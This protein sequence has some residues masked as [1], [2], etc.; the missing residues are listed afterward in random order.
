MAIASPSLGV[1]M[2]PGVS[3]IMTP[4]PERKRDRLMLETPPLA[5]GTPD[6]AHR[7]MAAARHSQYRNDRD[8]P[9]NSATRNTTPS[10]ERS[11]PIKLRR[12]SVAKPPQ[13][14]LS[15]AST[16]QVYREHQNTNPTAQYLTVRIDKGPSESLGMSV[17]GRPST[18]FARHSHSHHIVPLC[19]CV[20]T[21]ASSSSDCRSPSPFF[22]APAAKIPGSG[23]PRLPM[24]DPLPAREAWSR[25][26]G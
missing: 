16:E 14:A 22:W 13:F 12:R 18:R 7:P 4:F 19:T 11:T 9:P 6:S 1:I 2:G 26:T 17:T 24:A 15:E 21:K 5:A 20:A 10:R 23:W 8:L 3:P 25:V